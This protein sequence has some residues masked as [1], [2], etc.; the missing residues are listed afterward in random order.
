MSITGGG[1]KEY[2]AGMRVWVGLRVGVL[3]SCMCGLRVH[4]AIVSMNHKRHLASADL[5]R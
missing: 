4:C 3:R 2:A 5:S 1:G